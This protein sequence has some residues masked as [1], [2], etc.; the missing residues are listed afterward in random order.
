MN[1]LTF[2]ASTKSRSISLGLSI[3]E[4]TAFFVISLNEIL[5]VLY[6]EKISASLQAM[7]SPSLSGSVAM[8]TVST[9]CFSAFF[10]SP[11]TVLSAFVSVQSHGGSGK[12]S[13]LEAHMAFLACFLSLAEYPGKS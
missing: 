10:S 9:E 8:N 13:G 11:L 6:S 2:A 7:N 4:I 3:A 1:L 5:I 12:E